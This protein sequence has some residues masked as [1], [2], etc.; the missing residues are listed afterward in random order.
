MTRF[1][2]RYHS[3]QIDAEGRGTDC[4]VVMD[5]RTNEQVTPPLPYHA[6]NDY[7]GARNNPSTTEEPLPLYGWAGL[8]SV[9]AIP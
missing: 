2:P 3:R 6:A 7:A 5:S 9:M 8:G 1:F 4:Y